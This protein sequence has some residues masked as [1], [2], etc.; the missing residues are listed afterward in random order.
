MFLS[1]ALMVLGYVR[2]LGVL[3]VNTSHIDQVS[4]NWS[5]EKI[6]YGISEV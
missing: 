6:V 2:L 5:E 3:R 4:R 1:S